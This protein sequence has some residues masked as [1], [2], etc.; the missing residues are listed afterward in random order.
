MSF[1]FTGL[2]ADHVIK[3]SPIWGSSCRFVDFSDPF[4]GT[5]IRITGP[6]SD[7]AGKHLT[8]TALAWTK[9]NPQVRLMALD[10]STWAGA[11]DS[12]VGFVMHDGVNGAARQGDDNAAEEAFAKL[13][14][15][16]GKPLVTGHFA[17]FFSIERS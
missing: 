16:L 7:G 6:L 4:V 3:P 9:A 12:C 2:I 1:S 17:P 8:S 13:F 15:D 14:S 11:I 5:L 10:Y